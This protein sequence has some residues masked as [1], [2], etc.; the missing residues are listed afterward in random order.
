MPLLG[1]ADAVSTEPRFWLSCPS[2][3]PRTTMMWRLASCSNP[4]SLVGYLG[5]LNDG[6]PDLLLFS[7]FSGR[8]F[9]IT[10]FVSNN[11]PP[12]VLRFGKKIYRSVARLHTNFLMNH[13]KLLELDPLKNFSIQSLRGK[14][15]Q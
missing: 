4:A 10:A 7:P 12:L 5:P 11:D 14:V 9:S 6:G 2:S 3:A 8:Y 1:T 13:N 15:A